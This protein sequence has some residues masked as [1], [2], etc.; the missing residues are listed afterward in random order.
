[1]E[2]ACKVTGAKLIMVMTHHNCGVIKA[3]IDNVQLGNITSLANKIKSAVEM[4][5]TFEGEK[6]LKM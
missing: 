1:M 5:A 4:S 2:F 3:S 6:H